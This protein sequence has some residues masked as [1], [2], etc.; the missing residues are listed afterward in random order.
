MTSHLP[1]HSALSPGWLTEAGLA[2][3]QRIELAQVHVLQVVQLRKVSVK[4]RKYLPVDLPD[5]VPDSPPHLPRRRIG[6]PVNGKAR[7]RIELPDRG[8][9]TR[10]NLSNRGEKNCTLL[11]SSFDAARV[12]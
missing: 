10:G 8:K 5:R 12:S 2:P 7:D 11:P 6:L 9:S 3:E 1:V 4:S